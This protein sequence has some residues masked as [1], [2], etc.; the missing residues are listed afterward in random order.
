MKNYILELV[1]LISGA[2]VMIF[3]LV[4]SRILAPYLG[5]SLPV[6][7]SLIGIVL[8]SL[9]LGY[10]WGG[11]LADKKPS[12]GTL[13]LILVSA[14]ALIGFTA[15][16]KLYIL[17]TIYVYIA[18][19]RVGSVVAAVLL[20]AP[21]SIFLGM[22]SP[23]AVRL[24][25]KTLETSGNV[26]GRLYAISTVGSIVGTF[27]AG[28]I[29]VPHLG[30]TKILYLLLVL[31][32]FCAIIMS[33][34]KMMA[35]RIR[36]IFLFSL[37]LLFYTISLVQASILPSL[38]TD[39]ETQYNSLRIFETKDQKTGRPIRGMSTDPHG[40]QG[41]M[42]LDED[43]DLVFDYLKYYRLAEHF[44]PKIERSLFIG[45]GVYAFPKD[46]VKRNKDAVIDV[47]EI[48]Q[49]ITETAKKYFNFNDNDRINVI[50][51]DGRT[52]LNRNRSKYDVIY[53][54]AF[55]AHLAIPFQLT[56]SEAV[57]IIYN[58]LEDEGV[59]LAN[60]ISSIEG[61][62]GK[63]LQAEVKTYQE[64]FPQVYVFSVNP[65]RDSHD[66]G[67]LMLIALKSDIVPAFV[68]EDRELNKYLATVWNKEIK[69][70]LPVLTDEFAPVDYYTMKLIK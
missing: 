3:E 15:I 22:V 47:V 6:W 21:A 27:L 50:H 5:T 51:E 23:Y 49:G 59:V 44:A 41:A 20:F 24:R 69:T 58:T 65:N 33:P 14:A 43:N 62:N 26:V 11:K 16:A 31:L 32:L 64:F 17:A 9:S 34:S 57:E 56:T 10:F 67:N 39:I 8:G 13:S 7:T 63:F 42:F 70:N 66:M 19:I 40:T 25:L 68:G 4:G 36:N 12:R 1:I 60:I 55:N 28:F 45:G 53:L 38:Y 37:L 61:E 2:V 52:F 46:Y 18:D 35:L 30:S 29:L 54:D 48:D